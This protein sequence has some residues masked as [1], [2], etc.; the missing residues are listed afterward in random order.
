MNS[1]NWMARLV[2]TFFFLLLLA[3]CVQSSYMRDVPPGSAD[4]EPAPGKALMVFMR[5]SAF[6]GAIQSSVFDVTGEKLEFVGIVSA[7]TKVAYQLPPGDHHFMVIG[8]NADF[9]GA[10]VEPGKIYYALVTP[11]MGIWKARFSLKPLTKEQLGTEQFTAWYDDCRWVENSEQSRQWEKENRLSI[12]EKRSD[13]W[14]KWESKPDKPI[15]RATD[16]T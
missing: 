15:L 14:P 16:G 4:F 9:M 1:Y 8:E 12:M 10:A 6:G 7:K 3:G 2:L 11:R 5:P 13:Y